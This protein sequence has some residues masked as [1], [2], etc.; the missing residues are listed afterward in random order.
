MPT[1]PRVAIIAPGSMGA[2][3]GKLLTAKGLTV[4]TLTEGRSEAS[5]AR[6]EAAGMSSVSISDIADCDILLSIV[7]PAE[8]RSLA[9]ELVAA[10]AFRVHKPLY[11]DCNAIAPDEAVAIADIVTTAR[12]RFADA[13]IVGG[14][15][16][17]AGARSPLF[18]ISGEH[19]GIMEPLADY[20]LDIKLL[21]APVG[22]ASALKMAVAGISKGMTGILSLMIMVAERAG[23][24]DAFME[25]LERSQPGLVSWG[26][27]QIPTLDR[28]AYR[29]VAEMEALERLAQK[30]PGG[31]SLY[32]GLAELYAWI[33][34]EAG[35]SEDLSHLLS[36]FPRPD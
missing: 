34:Q 16:T 24:A 36:R 8:A 29:W 12:C 1:S 26:K 30:V 21:D 2:A 13:G 10:G 5:R 20:G 31:E 28:R 3:I 18:Y 17:G 25:Q 19:A 23:V 7:P 4:T 27:R 22:S 15:P 14:A 11:V 33:A 35:D 6:A 32:A 9:E